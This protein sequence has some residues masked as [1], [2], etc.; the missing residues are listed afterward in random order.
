MVAAEDTGQREIHSVLENL[1]D[2]GVCASGFGGRP[3]GR[4]TRS[5]AVRP[6]RLQES[7]PHGFET[8]ARKTQDEALRRSAIRELESLLKDDSKEIRTEAA[9]SLKKISRSEEV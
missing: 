4:K 8:L 2:L 1:A 3:S 9:A 5:G 7:F 6:A